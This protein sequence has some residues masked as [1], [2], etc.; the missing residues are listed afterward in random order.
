MVQV[1]PLSTSS[2]PVSV[3]VSALYS[4][5]VQSILVTNEG[6]IRRLWDQVLEIASSSASA[7]AQ[8]LLEGGGG[9]GGMS[10]PRV[11]HVVKLF[12]ALRGSAVAEDGATVLT[13]LEVN[14]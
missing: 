11:K 3:F 13:V 7:S 10:R 5:P 12:L 1:E 6:S 9:G 14:E 2:R 8:T 4:H